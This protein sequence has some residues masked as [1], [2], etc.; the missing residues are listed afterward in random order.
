MLNVYSYIDFR[1][2][3]ND[4]ITEKK[5]TNPKFSI[6]LMAQK[7]GISPGTLVRILNGKRNLSSNL[8]PHLITLLKLRERSA[9]YFSL[10]VAFDQCKHTH[11]KNEL[12]E[13]ILSFR[14]ERIKKVTKSQYALFDKWYYG[15]V[16]EMIEIHGPL[17]DY[18]ELAP[19][20]RPPVP[21][22]K[23]E[24]AVQIL[25]A[26]GLIK[27]HNDGSLISADRF[28]TTGERWESFAIQ[29]FQKEML[30]LAAGAGLLS[31]ERQEEHYHG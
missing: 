4:F 5:S 28:L 13:K 6:R 3:L 7:L 17:K 12:Y 9:T 30:D 24:K 21:L 18:H 20:I 27:K 1:K 14:N 2:F 26:E 16:R 31:Q 25:L 22:R 15:V 29:R 11:E 19:L 10:L 8:L 23:I